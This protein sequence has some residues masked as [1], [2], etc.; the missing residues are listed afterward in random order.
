MYK[1]T[2]PPESA[3]WLYVVLV[4][5]VILEVILIYILYS[6]LHSVLAFFMKRYYNCHK[7]W[8]GFKRE[9]DR[10]WL[11]VDSSEKQKRDEAK[12]TAYDGW[13][14]KSLENTLYYK[15]KYNEY[16]AKY[17]GQSYESSEDEAARIAREV[18]DDMSGG[19]W[20]DY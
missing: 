20:G 19:N 11:S 14:Y 13:K 7:E 15:E 10:Y 1:Q 9:A 4:V 12:N 2:T 5:I 16:Y 3:I 18:H 17:M 6:R 8:E